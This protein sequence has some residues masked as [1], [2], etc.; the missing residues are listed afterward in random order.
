MMIGARRL[1]FV[2]PKLIGFRFSPAAGRRFQFDRIGNLYIAVKNS[3]SQITKNK[4]ITMTN[5]QNNKPVYVPFGVGVKTWLKNKSCR[6][7]FQELVFSLSQNIST[8]PTKPQFL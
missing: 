4:Q 5:I 3:K 8:R 1:R 6:L 7:E 2:R